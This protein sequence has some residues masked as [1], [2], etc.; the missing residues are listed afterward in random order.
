[1]EN[2]NWRFGLAL[3]LIEDSLSN[4]E[5]GEVQH[6]ALQI[7][8]KD[9]T[10]SESTLKQATSTGSSNYQINGEVTNLVERM[11]V[12][13]FGLRAFGYIKPI[14][15]KLNDIQL[16][17]FLSGNAYLGFN[18][19]RYLLKQ[20]NMPSLV[21]T[22]QVDRIFKETIPLIPGR[23]KSG[24]KIA[25]LDTAKTTYEEITKTDTWKDDRPGIMV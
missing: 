23:D 8:F 7:H 6:L 4:I 13:D 22:W 19:E 3:W 1:M 18:M 17:S 24:K 9:C 14:S 10:K 2:K 5:V 20:P 12:I 21:Y 25:T 16:G 15:D 11:L